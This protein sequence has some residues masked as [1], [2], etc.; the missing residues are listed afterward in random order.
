MTDTTI[1]DLIIA[2]LAMLCGSGL[3]YF[4]STGKGNNPDVNE[5]PAKRKTPAGKVDEKGWK[6]E[7]QTVGDPGKG[8]L[9]EGVKPGEIATRIEAE[10]KIEGQPAHDKET[11]AFV[12]FLKNKYLLFLLICFSCAADTIPVERA[13]FMQMILKLERL[14][15]IEEAK[16]I[17]Q[18]NNIELLYDSDGRIY[19]KPE[20]SGTLNIHDLSYKLGVNLKVNTIHRRKKQQGRLFSLSFLY[21]DETWNMV[22]T[23]REHKPLWGLAGTIELWTIRP[24]VYGTL[25]SYG[26]GLR[27][28]VYGNFGMLF[29]A[30]YPGWTPRIGALFRL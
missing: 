8:E 19:S 25:E 9:P 5:A 26:I 4:M 22:T 17:F 15:T 23:C 2:I 16:P 24:L 27:L 11:K 20:L 28:P 14:A 10:I 30:D 18:L 3:I 21:C 6:Q 29:G 13:D 7:P 1:H 12:D